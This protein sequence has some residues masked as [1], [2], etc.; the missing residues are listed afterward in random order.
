MSY[1]TE[2]PPSNASLP[3]TKSPSFCF[4]EVPGDMVLTEKYLPTW[5]TAVALSDLGLSK[6]F[7]FYGEC[8][9]SSIT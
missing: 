9:S 5:P 4:L 7:L 6:E 1:D 2:I 3:S 8:A